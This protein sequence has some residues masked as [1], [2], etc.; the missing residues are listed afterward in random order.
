[1]G[2]LVYL[3][4]IITGDALPIAKLTPFGQSLTVNF[5]GGKI[6]TESSSSIGAILLTFKVNGE[7]TLT[8]NTAMTLAQANVDGSLKVLLY[9]I[10]TKSISSGLNEIIGV[11]GNVELVTAEASDY[12]GNMLSLKLSIASLPKEFALSQNYPNPFNPA[13]VIEFAL[14]T[15]SDVSLKIYNLAG[16]TVATIING[17]MPAG[18]HQV[19]W[20]GID[21]AGHGVSS[22]VYFYK[23][24]VGT[25][26]ETRKMLLVK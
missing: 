15:A 18:Y 11:T 23:I 6:T 2:D 13:T 25:F 26:S 7:F 14:P 4:R 24:D 12:N 19:R 22:G 5:D 9:D 17:A 21:A 1:V 10:S 20:D 3:I 16:Q 8:N